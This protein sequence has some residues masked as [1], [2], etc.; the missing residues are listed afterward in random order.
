M[1]M[2]CSSGASDPKHEIK[3][4]TPLDKPY[5]LLWPI[6]PFSFGGITRMVERDPAR[7]TLVELVGIEQPGMKEP[8]RASILEGPLQYLGEETIETAGRKW[9]AHKFS[10]KV[11][12]HPQFLI[13]TSP[14]G[15]LLAFVMEHEHKEWAEEGMRLTRL[16]STTEF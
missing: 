2:D 8:V 7:A 4:R 12:T 15:L 16:E 10:L 1:Q 9:L 11:P 3:L 13:W 5:G 14:K 6:S